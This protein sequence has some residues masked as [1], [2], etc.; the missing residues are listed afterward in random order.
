MKIEYLDREAVL[1]A[2]ALFTAELA[3]MH[4]EI[5]RILLFGSYERGIPLPSSDIDLFI[6]LSESD[7]RFL[8]RTAFYAPDRFPVGVDIFPYTED[9][10]ETMLN[11][12]NQFV[13]RALE[14]GRL[15]FSRD[16]AP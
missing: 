11:E 14:T 4:P 10:L 15:L 3:E 5:Q 6:V 1:E 16:P 9:E 12:G 13:R 7:R 8:D 2:L